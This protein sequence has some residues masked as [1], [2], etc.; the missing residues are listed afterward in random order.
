M[1]D[2]SER[3]DEVCYLLSSEWNMQD[4]EAVEILLASQ[5]PMARFKYP[6]LILETQCYSFDMSAA[7]FNLGGDT[8]VSLPQF[9][10]KRPRAGNEDITRVLADRERPALFIEPNFEGPSNPHYKLVM[11]PYLTQNCLRVRSRYPKAPPIRPGRLGVLA[12]AVKSVMD[13]RWREP[14]KDEG[15]VPWLLYYAEILQRL[16]ETQRDWSTLVEN[17]IALAHRR[18]YLF[19]R[20]VDS[21]DWQAVLRVMR[22]S[23]PIVTGKIISQF[24]SVGRWHSLRGLYPERFISREVKRL[25]GE[26]LVYSH[27]GRWRL[28]DPEGLGK[29]VLAL[30]SGQVEV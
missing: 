28:V 29:D 11:M 2:Y 18:A 6:W 19:N 13:N 26:G 5:L 15:A 3:I 16:S 10:V 21:T 9:R 20:G 4:R 12:A 27:A 24:D 23:V 30:I 1:I 25:L 17:L 14:E 7:W 22:D 8:A